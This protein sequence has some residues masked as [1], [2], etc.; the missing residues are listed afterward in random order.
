MAGWRRWIALGSL[1][2][3][4]M[5]QGQVARASADVR[6]GKDFIAG[7][8]EKLPPVGFEKPGQYRGRV[9]AF[10]LI[11]IDASSRQLVVA[12]RIDGEF[13][14]PVNGPI[15]DRVARS[16]HTPEGW[17]KFGFDVRARVNVE[18]GGDA[19]PRF[20]IGIDEVKRRDL[21]GATGLVA[22]ALGQLFDDIV[23]QFANGRAS[24]LSERL[25]IEIGR[26]VALFKEYGVFCGI[27]YAPTEL[28][29]HFDLTRLRSEGVTGYVFPAAQT[30]TVPLYRWLH[31]GDRSHFYTIRPA[32][33]DR[34][35]AVYEGVAGHV[36]DHRA[37]GAVPLFRWSSPHDQL[38]TTAPDGEH[39]DRLGYRPR[40]IA[41]YIDH[42]PKPGSVPLYRFFDPARRQHFYTTHPHA[43]FM[44]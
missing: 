12:C 33:P 14:A 17:R 36:Y 42:K 7:I 9:H 5:A 1:A 28:V 38:Y 44:K 10:Q 37:E 26:R 34:P 25:N 19:A 22:K 27:E 43:E 21:D 18:P 3:A 40:G 20:R 8:I 30:G 35:N 16:P 41:C 2:W 6:L 4:A 39:A 32:A 15:S 13:H 23:T 24:R 29:L 31:P 11:G